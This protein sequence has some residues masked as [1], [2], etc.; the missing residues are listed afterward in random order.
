MK[1]RPTLDPFPEVDYT[2][3]LAGRPESLTQ[4]LVGILAG[5][6]VYVTLIPAALDGG[7]R[8]GWFFRGQP[9]AY[10]DYKKQ[11][12]AYE[13]PDGLIVGHLALGLL[14]LISILTVAFV[15]Q[16]KPK[17][18]ASVQPGMRW[19][20]LLLCVPIAVVVLSGG[21]WIPMIGKSINWNPTNNWQIWLVAILLVTP[22]QAAGE[23]FF[24]RGYLI[25]A[26]G[27]ITRSKWASVILS[28]LVFAVF[29]GTQNLPLFLDRLGFGLLAGALVIFTGGIEAAI[30]IHAVNNVLSFG[31]AT[32]MG[33]VAE[34]R[35]IQE[36]TWIVAG[37]DVLVFACAA[38]IC[39]WL[40][41][42][43]QVAVTTPASLA[44][45]HPK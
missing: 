2:K 23:E 33:G 38:A 37:R 19:R 18:L 17:W 16:T 45:E 29:H 25:Q 8:L 12:L 13:I 22:L 31:L 11:A 10:A 44:Q 20:Y 41:S 35:A 21:V 7:L 34:I 32:M 43:L 28:A 27:S 30:A 9:G 3:T 26:L 5:L 40:G 6:M 42:K 15:H 36:I 24:F 4:A 1:F 14:M 39:W